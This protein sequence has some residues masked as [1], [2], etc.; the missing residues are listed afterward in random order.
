MCV[1][2]VEFFSCIRSV[3][4]DHVSLSRVNGSEGVE[5]RDISSAETSS[6]L[7]EQSFFCVKSA[8]CTLIECI[9]YSRVKGRV[10]V[11][12]LLAVVHWQLLRNAVP[13]S[14]GRKCMSCII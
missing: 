14:G 2:G 13:G 10:L 11:Y 4:L 12:K 8:P 9:M 6:W 1:C 7:V 5:S 3:G